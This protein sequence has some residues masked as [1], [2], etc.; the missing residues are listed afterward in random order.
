MKIVPLTKEIIEAYDG[1]T[2]KSVRGFAVEENGKILGCA[3][4]YLNSGHLM[5]W[6]DAKDELR[7]KPIAMVKLCKKLWTLPHGNRVYAYCDRNFEA[8]GRFL[9]HF[10]FRDRGDGFFVLE[11]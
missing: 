5:V 1:E 7:K 3:G 9:E 6:M 4:S 11:K 10:G 8:A 2:P